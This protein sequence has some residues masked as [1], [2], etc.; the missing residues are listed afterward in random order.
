[1]ADSH[2]KLLV[3]L[4][5]SMFLG[6]CASRIQAPTSDL[7]NVGGDNSARIA[8]AQNAGTGEKY[9]PV[10]DEIVSNETLKAWRVALAHSERG[11]LSEA[12]WNEARKRDEEESMT[13]LKS[14]AQRFPKASFISTMMGQVKQHFGK[15]TEAAAYYEEATLQNRNDPILI[16]KAAEMRRKSGSTE[17]ALSYYKKVIELQPNFPGAK[18]GMARCLLS[19]KKTAEDGRKLITEILARDPQ[20]TEAQA[21]LAETKNK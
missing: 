10:E 18:L 16:F 7:S 1:M 3:A 17:R 21:A 9:D 5:A 19:D 2:N 6:A 4:S 15:K 13:M 20:D 8:N 12:A 14:L 11:T